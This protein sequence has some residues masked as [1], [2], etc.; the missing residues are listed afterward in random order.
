MRAQRLVTTLATTLAASWEHYASSGGDT[1]LTS[2]NLQA[3]IDSNGYGDSDVQ[4]KF[5]N[6]GY[7]GASSG[8]DLQSDLDA[9]NVI[10]KAAFDAAS[11]T[12]P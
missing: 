6:L 4:N 9:G 8:T 5:R 7:T 3:H 1:Y 10:T 11:T 12:Y 2:T